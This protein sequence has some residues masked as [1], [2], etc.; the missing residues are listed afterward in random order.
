[1]E[2]KEIQDK[3]ISICNKELE[4]LR[5]KYLIYTDLKE[6]INLKD[7][8]ISIENKIKYYE[9]RLNENLKGGLKK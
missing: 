3:I 8:L 9:G 7:L 2:N 6:Y 1:M 4:V 5:I